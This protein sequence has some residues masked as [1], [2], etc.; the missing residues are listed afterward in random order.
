MGRA[1]GRGNMET[2]ASECG[3]M[4]GH[5]CSTF[6][7]IAALCLSNAEP[8]THGAQVDE[9]TANLWRCA[10]GPIVCEIACQQQQLTSVAGVPRQTC[11][12]LRHRTRLMPTPANHAAPMILSE[13]Y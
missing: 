4:H 10:S 3:L 6:M 7:G 12:V 2:G 9:Y 1:G 8:V 11:A 5:T 13:D